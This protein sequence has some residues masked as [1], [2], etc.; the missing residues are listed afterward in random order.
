MKVIIDID[1][2]K[3]FLY[4]ESCLGKSGY[5]IPEQIDEIIEYIEE[6]GEG[7]DY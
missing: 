5:S 7:L 1:E 2:L 3:D 4:T 6:Y